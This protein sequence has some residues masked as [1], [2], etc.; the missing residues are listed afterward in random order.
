MREKVNAGVVR[1]AREV[2]EEEKDYEY[3]LFVSFS[4][5]ELL[6]MAR[7][8]KFSIPFLIIA[9]CIAS[10]TAWEYFVFRCCY[11][12]VLLATVACLS[13]VTLRVKT[14]PFT[15]LQKSIF[16]FSRKNILFLQ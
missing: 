12:L 1:A 14:D 10:I 16:Y 8:T 7:P 11:N 15:C 5:V 3:R 13:Y 9:S 6:R 2:A 4:S